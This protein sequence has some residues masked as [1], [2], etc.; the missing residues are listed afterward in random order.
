MSQEELKEAVSRPRAI[1]EDLQIIP[2]FD[3][4][5]AIMKTMIWQIK[6]RNNKKIAKIFAQA[7]YEELMS[8]LEE[9]IQLENLTNPIIIPIPLSKKRFHMR[10]YNQCELVLSEFKKIDSQNIFEYKK[11]ILIKIFDTPTQT[12]T[13]SRDERLKNLAHC[14]AVR[15]PSLIQNRFVILLDDVTTTGTTLSHARR[16]LLSSDARKVIC[17]ALAH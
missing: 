12:S 13:K 17:I 16:V 9:F 14:F 1:H 6:Y 5:N 15:D 2:L 8:E 4:Q 11:D 10:G 7:L 3:Y